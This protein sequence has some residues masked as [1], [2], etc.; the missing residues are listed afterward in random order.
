M[1]VNFIEE[2]LLRKVMG[3]FRLWIDLERLYLFNFLK[4]DR[5]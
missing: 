2:E 3:H 1:I 5:M 4:L